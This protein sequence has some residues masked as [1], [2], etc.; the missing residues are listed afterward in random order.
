[1]KKEPTEDTSA[2]GEACEGDWEPQAGGRV[3]ISDWVLCE[4]FSAPVL[5]EPLKGV[6]R[7]LSSYQG[8][9]AGK[10]QWPGQSS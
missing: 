3:E 9:G 7:Q 2:N 5:F 4:V 1:M 10:R 8:T 6:G